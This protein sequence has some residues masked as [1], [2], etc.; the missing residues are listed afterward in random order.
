MAASQPGWFNPQFFTS[1]GD[2]A[3]SYRLYTYT[4]G[5]TT[6]KTAYTES[7]GTTAHTYTS[8]GVGGQYIATN[9]RGELPSPLYLTS[10]AYDLLLKTV[11][12]ATVW[13][14]RAAG[15][16]D[17]SATLD[18]ALRAE[19]AAVDD[20]D[21]GGGMVGVSHSI[22]YAA[23][24][25][26][27][28]TNLDIHTESFRAAGSDLA[29]LQAA[30]AFA[31]SISAPCLIVDSVGYTVAETVTFDLPSNS[32]IQFR[33]LITSS[34]S[35]ASA[36]IIGSTST[37]TNRLIVEGIK[38]VRTAN[39]TS[40]SS[41]GVECRSLV[42]SKVDVRLITGFRDGLLVNGTSVNGGSS[43]NDFHLGMLHDNRTNL[44][45]T[46]S[47]VGYCN[48]QR[49]YGGSFSHSTGYPAV[50]TLNIKIDHFA[51]NELNNN[52]FFC[53]SLEDNAATSEA[54]E[55]NG[56]NNVI[57]WPRMERVASQSTYLITFTADSAE[58]SLE[59][60]G[61]TLLNSNISDLGTNNSYST[62][63]G[64]RINTQTEDDAAKASWSLQ[65]STT[66]NARLLMGRDSSGVV[67]WF[68]RGNGE[69]TLRNLVLNNLGNYTNDAN[70]A[71][72]GVAVGGLYHNSGA[73]RV[74]I[75]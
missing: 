59:G 34:V 22:A 14:R 65:S 19:L 15:T 75:S 13:T 23:G 3:E 4:A 9:A 67:Q 27:H 35:N 62:R 36:I 60:D 64:T 44:R 33:G 71:A 7:T 41:V 25:L 20:A 8:D 74:R 2:L 42:W 57:Y 53:P 1:Q 45:L 56:S 40:G 54:A 29:T 70:A 6:H 69:A 63:E 10:G 49:F 21:E 48:E 43:H 17:V 58:C 38:V 46:A 24:T 52:R 37:N 32:I 61:F 12:G 18:T 31:K 39:D 68:I 47:G 50:T 73:L 55:I 66:S 51:S 72:G 5:T 28:R 11:A 30:I 26:G 16:D